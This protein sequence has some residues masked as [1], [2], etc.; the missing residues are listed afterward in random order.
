[1]S[2]GL[3]GISFLGEEFVLS[4]EVQKPLYP[5]A[6][7]F[8][9]TRLVACGRFAGL[10][11]ETKL[12]ALPEQIADLPVEQTGIEQGDIHSYL[13]NGLIALGVDGKLATPGFKLEEVETQHDMHEL[14]LPRWIRG[15]RK[16]RGINEQERSFPAVFEKYLLAALVTQ[17]RRAFGAQPQSGNAVKLSNPL[18]VPFR[19]ASSAWVCVVKIEK[20]GVTRGRNDRSRFMAISVGYVSS[21]PKHVSLKLVVFI[22]AMRQDHV[23]DCFTDSAKAMPKEANRVYRS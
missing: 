8:R 12:R 9:K 6:G 14:F 20:A 15:Q 11:R 13:V 18:Q 23:F 16:Q 21:V 5:A 7:A 22:N 1:M 4:I 19:R 2:E 3:V 17:A 10:Q